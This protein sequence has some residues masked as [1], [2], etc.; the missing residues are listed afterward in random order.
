LLS[1]SKTDSHEPELLS[2]EFAGP[3]EQ[4]TIAVK[5]KTKPK[6]KEPIKRKQTFLSLQE[7]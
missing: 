2:I 5:V 3:Q 6:R 7:K 4:T 1:R